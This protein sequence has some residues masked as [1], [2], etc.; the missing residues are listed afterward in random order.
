MILDFGFGFGVGGILWL[1]LDAS[2]A[3]YA[4]LSK[5]F[6]IFFIKKNCNKKLERKTKKKKGIWLFQFGEENMTIKEK[7]GIGLCIWAQY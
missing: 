7:G 5:I 3:I 2:T 4:T 1:V 6:I